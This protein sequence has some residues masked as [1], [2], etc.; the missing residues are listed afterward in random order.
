MKFKNLKKFKIVKLNLKGIYIL[1]ILNAIF[2]LGCETKKAKQFSIL[3]DSNIYKQSQVY[4]PRKIDV[5]WVIDNS[6]SMK[7]SQQNLANNFESF[8]DK[9]QKLKFNFRIGVT[10]TDAYRTLYDSSAINHSHLRDGDDS[11]LGHSGI[12]VIDKETP[13]L[14]ETFVVNAMLGIKGTKNKNGFY[15]NSGD[16]RAFQSMQATLERTETINEFRRPEAFLA[17]IILSD[18]DDFSRPGLYSSTNQSVYTNPNLHTIQ[19]YVDFLDSYT[20]RIGPDQPANYSVSTINVVDSACSLQL[21]S[22]GFVR[23]P[24]IR[25]NELATLTGGHI[26]SLCEPFDDTL[27]SISDLILDQA[28]IFA[29]TRVPVLE[30]IKVYVNDLLIS[31]DPVNGWTYRAEDNS[32]HFHGLGIPTVGSSIRI[33]FDPT[34]IKL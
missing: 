11:E 19:S 24:G 25:Y 28:S 18:E 20:Q 34:T 27:A 15:I 14:V 21:N 7:T 30:S 33:D 3:P 1:L 13:N 26:G 31:E 6:G 12:F 29:L 8:V 9:F 22:D 17:I 4:E 10:A 2:N 5:L 32:I 16:E 23:Y